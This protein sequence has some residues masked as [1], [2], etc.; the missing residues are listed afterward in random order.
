M[1]NFYYIQLKRE[2]TDWGNLLYTDTDS[3]LLAIYTNVYKDNKK[4]ETEYDLSNYNPDH[5][6]NNP[7]NKKVI[8]KMKD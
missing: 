6:L 2:Y 5:P 7:K 4:W 8:S 3:L 1:Y